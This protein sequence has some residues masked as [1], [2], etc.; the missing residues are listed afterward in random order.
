MKLIE[1][2][3]KH[4]EKGFTIKVTTCNKKTATTQN[5]ETGEIAT[6]NRAK[7]EWMIK[8]GIFTQVDNLAEPE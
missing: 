1:N 8:K 4:S 6:F 2:I 5:C 7:F 3:Y